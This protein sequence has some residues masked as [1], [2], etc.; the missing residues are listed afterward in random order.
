[1]E[2]DYLARLIEESFEDPEVKEVGMYIM[3]RLL[4]SEV[5]IKGL[6]TG[7]TNVGVLPEA[8]ALALQYDANVT[9]NSFY[10]KNF[11]V[12]KIQISM[13]EIK[14]SSQRLK[15]QYGVD[16]NDVNM[17]RS[18]MYLIQNKYDSLTTVAFLYKGAKF[19][20]EFDFKLRAITTLSDQEIQ[21][22][23]SKG[24]R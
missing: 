21:F 7:R 13:D 10:I 1:M 20:K 17:L 16:K 5:A 18:A 4:L 19:A 2:Q 8:L 11:A 23:E 24:V 12:I 15:L 6:M 3:S 9:D 22:F 14:L